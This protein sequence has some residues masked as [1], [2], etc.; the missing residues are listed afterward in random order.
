MTPGRT[1]RAAARARGRNLARAGVFNR[2]DGGSFLSED[3]MSKAW[4]TGALAFAL[5]ACGSGSTPSPAFTDGTPDVAG[6]ALETSGGAPDGL[7]TDALPA[8]NARAAASCEPWEYL[9]RLQEG[10][11]SLNQFVRAVVDPIEALALAAPATSSAVEGVYGPIDAPASSPV[12][13]FRLT[14]R[15]AAPATYRF[16]LEG[17][18]VGAAD[19]NYAVVLAGELT[20]SAAPHRGQGVLGIDLAKL[21]ALNTSGS[22]VTG[23]SG[24]GLILGSFVNTAGTKSLVYAVQ[25]FVP[26]TT[27]AGAS[28]L[29]AAFVGHKTTSG[30]TR[31]RLAS[32]SDYLVSKSGAD[33]GLELLLSRGHWLPGVGGRAAVVVEDAGG[34]TNVASYGASFFLGLSCWNTAL[35]EG[36]H[37]LFACE[38]G[39]PASCVSAPASTLASWPSTS[40]ADA[41]AACLPGTELADASSPPA[42]DPSST[43]PE[44]GAPATPG[45]LPA[46][47]TELVF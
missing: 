13:T 42:T 4:R 9:C 29:D 28:P 44:P 16:K 23:F 32:L 36:Y 19:A 6:L 30:E 20:P 24:Q 47:L 31:V 39:P 7:A 33:T 1:P 2:S 18:P 45:P 27:V 34:A 21:A 43:A 15:L 8:A 37:G 10:V 26:D 46:S 22:A 41:A 40:A 38:D 11:R 12:A 25:G 3:G 5:A 14:V 35:L 17:K